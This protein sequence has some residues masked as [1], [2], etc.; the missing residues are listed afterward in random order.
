MHIL[1]PHCRNP[2]EVVKLSSR[3]EITCPSCGS[4]F[5]LESDSTTGW[6]RG[7]GQKLGKFE[8][9]D[10][11]GH[12]AFGTVYKARDPE[13]DRTVALKV[14]RAGNLAGPQE[15]DR[16]LREARSAAQLRHPSIVTVH[17]VGQVDGV[18][19]LVSDFVE[20]V[21][22][23]DLVSARR[24]GFRESAVLVA[25]V[26][27][28]LQY[29]HEH[30]VVHRDVKP[31]NIMIGDDG[32]P[33][34]MDF[35]LAKRDAGE[36]TM[37]VEGQVLGTP[38]YMPPEQAR[39]EGHAVDARGDV[40][41]LG[42][43]L[44]QLLTG[45]L[46]FRGTQRMLLH[47]VL[48]DDP[49]PPRQLNDRIAR[50]LETI[51]LMA[52]A[53]EAPRR[54]QTARDLADDLRRWLKGEPIQARPVGRL[55]RAARWA[56]RRP[57][58]AAL[59]AVSG[60]ALVAMVG[61][62]VGLVY[63]ARLAEA[64]EAEEEQRRKAEDALSLAEAA[65]QGEEQQRK[66]AEDALARAE[67][68]GYF[69]SIFLADVA[70]KENNVLLAQERLRECK[71]G[72]RGWEWR[73]LNAQCHRE[74][75]AVPGIVTFSPDGARLAVRGKDSVVLIYD[76]NTGAKAFQFKGPKHLYAPVF[77]PDGT[78]IAMR[79]DDGV[80][81]LY[82]AWTGAEVLQLKGTKGLSGPVFNPDGTRIAASAG[83]GT[84]R[85]YDARTGAE[86]LQFK[87][88][89][90]GSP[91]FSP[92]GMRIVVSRF[93]GMVRLHDARTGAVALEFNASGSRSFS[94]S[95]DG[96]RIVG[97][98]L[99]G[100]VP[101]Y[102]ARTGAVAVQLKGTA[103]LDNT[104][105][106]PD[107]TR[108]AAS[109]YDGI[110]WLYDT[111]TGA[112]VLQLKGT[113]GL[114]TPVFSPDGTQIA[115]SGRDGIVRLFDARMGDLA[116]QFSGPAHLSTPVFSPDG[117]RIAAWGQD[118]V[119]RVYDARHGAEAQLLMGSLGGTPV[120]SRDGARI[121]AATIHGEVRIYDARTGAETVVLKVS[122]TCPVILSHLA[123]RVRP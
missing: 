38:A 103:R 57:A 18:P 26:A 48:H 92:D 109:G 36:I 91:S 98:S 96:T 112:E 60:L 51:C 6:V 65:K 66:R 110:V 5:H 63:S 54:Y 95:Q 111:R 2:I 21:T 9:I 52:M 89:G 50:D 114:S 87:A 40:Y 25:A 47:Q 22:L 12:G 45:E 19:Y 13:L 122:Y 37:T 32:T 30:G 82:D 76:V 86:A 56:R 42:V 106:S 121:A 35:G 101:V 58:A 31:S 70:L 72:L 73:Y 16:F 100:V 3:E 123:L 79:G 94:F 116:L 61:L 43:V 78:R 7:A 64:Y 53:K 74:L 15:L 17:D 105:F 39:G 24:P 80:V 49:R 44:Y 75:F 81:R 118:G 62:V 99:T 34:I 97:S 29:A 107:G 69:H 20:G 93:G 46:P 117:T 14:P 1:C 83:D 8:L 113:K 67:R 120:F 77:S 108:I 23:T 68:I 90:F 88:S 115:A 28:A 71:Q 59:L 104:V 4:S 55:E 27:D 84:I 41:S 85:V 11:L 10:V 119:T 33:H 102:D